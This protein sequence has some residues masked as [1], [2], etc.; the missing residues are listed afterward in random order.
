MI[1]PIS[2]KEKKINTMK[3]YTPFRITGIIKNYLLIISLIMAST[4]AMG[5]MLKT[6]GKTIV[7]PDGNE[8]ILR[9]MGLGGW[10]LQEGYM[11]HSSDVANTQH[12]LKDR[13][14]SLMGEEKTEDFYNAWLEN[15]VTKKDI[16]SLAIWGFNSVR[17]PM[18]YN[19]FTFPIEDE[20]IAGENTW[21][22]K[23]F[24]M[25]DSLLQWCESN[26][27][28][29]ILDLHAAPGGQGKDEAISDYD[30]SKPSLWESQENR[31]KTVA[32][33]TKLAERYKDEPWI[34]GYDLL[35]EVNWTLPG[36]LMLK[37]LYMEITASIRALNDQHIIYIE[38]NS[39]A[40]D[41]T[42]LTPPWDDN[43]V[44][45]FHKY[46]SYNDPGSIQWVLDMREEH[47]VPLWMGEAGENSNTW[48]TEAIQLFEENDIGWSWWPMKRIET[49]VSPYSIMFTDGYKNVLA[50]WRNEVAQP[51]VEEAYAAMMELAYNTNS[52]QC[53]YQKDV[54]DA[55]I[56][57]VQTDETIPFT[58]HVI[59][60]VI[61]LSDFDLGKNNFA[62]YDKDV[63]NYSLSTGEFQA[64]NS[65]WSYRNDGVDIETNNDNINSNGYHIG[66]TNKGEWINY[67]LQIEESAAYTVKARV[68]SEQTGGEFHL[69][70]N[71]QD[72]THTQSIS[73]TGGWTTFENLEMA[74]VLLHAGEQVL[75]LHFDNNGAINMSSLEFIKTGNI[76]DIAFEAINGET[77]KDENA[78]DLILNQSLLSES[79]DGS[80]SSFVLMVNGEERTIS[81]LSFDESRDRT[82]SLIT[83]QALIYTDDIKLTYNGSDITSTNG[84][85]L[86]PFSNLIIRNTLPERFLLAT[87]IQAE[88]FFYMEGLGVEET[89]DLGG[90]HNIG[91]TNTGDFA[92]YLIYS[93]E[94]KT[95]EIDIR[96]AAQNAKGNI[97]FYLVQENGEEI[98]LVTKETPKTGGW[99]AWTTTSTRATIPK[100]IHTL[101]MKII[102]GELNLNWYDFK[103][104]D[105][106]NTIDASS[107]SQI[108]PNP[109]HINEIFIDLGD[110][111]DSQYTLDIYDLSGKVISSK[112]HRSNSGIIE[113]DLSDIPK[114]IFM[115][116]LFGAH[117][118]LSHKVIRQ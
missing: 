50:Y 103:I 95:Y 45:S 112:S 70:L 39:F 46:W 13:L 66:Y 73:S 90:G 26:Q 77:Q 14:I 93:P 48:F 32:L 4:L 76:E 91:Y 106:V 6:Q 17:L 16:D 65:G 21:L 64:W 19:L 85:V 42:G 96:V 37:N 15:H 104:V 94:D 109:V 88:D 80:I 47:N 118:I 116:R 3:S 9:G 23:V 113:V 59:P 11:M 2:I 78:I 31:D 101:R 24:I 60:G 92:D 114:G 117:K 107:E 34:G 7:D 79:I 25:V 28:Y 98:E 35:N 53:P 40:N 89:T 55:Q 29:L 38:G 43:M 110:N 86:N 84:K 97:G 61:H 83:E 75:S 111:N 5:Q 58:H 8:I 82:I 12:E 20:P 30:P 56:R 33:W 36:N 62:Y 115:F 71:G 68:A 54:H 44:Y 10:M 108:Y 1:N 69:S 74:N 63:A 18:H 99:Q 105:K 100:G 67:T 27:I 81:S 22:S 52:V 51:S 102:S 57:Q 87:R 49:T 72:V 41:F